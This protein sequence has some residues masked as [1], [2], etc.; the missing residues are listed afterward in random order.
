MDDDDTLHETLVDPD[1]LYG[2]QVIQTMIKKPG[3]LLITRICDVLL[4][5][6]YF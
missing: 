3:V 4:C 1:Y 6:F 2:P 5:M